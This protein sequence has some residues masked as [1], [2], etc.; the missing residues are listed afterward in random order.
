MSCPLSV[1]VQE[2]HLESVPLKQGSFAR[3]LVGSAAFDP[4]YSSLAVSSPNL[5]Q[6]QCDIHLSWAETIWQISDERSHF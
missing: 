6:T 5:L 4:L 3:N 2:L 1:T